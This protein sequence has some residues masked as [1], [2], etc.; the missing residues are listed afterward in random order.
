[1]KKDIPMKNWYVETGKVLFDKD[2]CKNTSALKEKNSVSQF[3]QQS[4]LEDETDE[5]DL[6]DSESHTQVG[7]SWCQRA[8]KIQSGDDT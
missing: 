7:W 2:L 4:N 3:F 8:S 1:M 6:D 5:E